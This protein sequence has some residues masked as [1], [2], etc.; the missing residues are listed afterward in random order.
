MTT[1]HSSDPLDSNCKICRGEVAKDPS[2]GGVTNYFQMT[3]YYRNKASWVIDWHVPMFVLQMSSQ[4]GYRQCISSTR[5]LLQ[6]MTL[7]CVALARKRTIIYVGSDF[8]ETCHSTTFWE[9]GV[10]SKVASH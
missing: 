4:N 3:L 2:L 9:N 8:T 6:A 10:L 1:F 5:L 7:G